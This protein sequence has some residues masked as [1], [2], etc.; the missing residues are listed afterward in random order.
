MAVYRDTPFFFSNNSFTEIQFTYYKIC[1]FVMCTF[2]GF[3]YI[4]VVLQP[5][6]LFNLK[7]V[8]LSPKE[9]PVCINSRSPD[10]QCPRPWQPLI[11]FLWICPFWA[12]NIIWM[13]F[14][15]YSSLSYHNLLKFY[16]VAH[17]SATFLFTSK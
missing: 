7:I 5:L 6:L 12:F 15:C 4:S 10:P 8:S 9:S 2:S 13:M 17:I 1:S 3:W 16:V 14:Y 11:C